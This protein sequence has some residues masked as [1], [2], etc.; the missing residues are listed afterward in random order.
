[1]KAIIHFVVFQSILVNITYG[2][3]KF[4]VKKL[5]ADSLVAL[6]PKKEGIEK[7]EAINLLSNV[8]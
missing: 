1:M 4:F 6:I 5:N 8:I 7:I 2:Q 3:V